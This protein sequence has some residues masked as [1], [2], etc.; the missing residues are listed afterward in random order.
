MNVLIID[1]KNLFTEYIRSLLDD[2]DPSINIFYSDN[3]LSA[4]QY[5]QNN[6]SPDLILLSINENCPENSYALIKKLYKL[7]LYIPMIV[8]SKIDSI[9]VATLAI[10]NKVSGYIS[11]KHSGEV[12]LDSVTYVL[13]EN[14]FTQPPLNNASIES[15]KSNTETK[16]IKQQILDLLNKGRMNNQ[17]AKELN[18]CS[19]TVN[20]YIHEL[21]RSLEDDN[22][23]NQ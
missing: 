13:E 8:M 3:I 7:R 21:L 17:I 19:N 10:E 12:I 15:K 11:Q 1:K 23:L 14:M 5:I 2:Y 9:E 20:A 22:K 4:Y 16:P 18:I 6:K